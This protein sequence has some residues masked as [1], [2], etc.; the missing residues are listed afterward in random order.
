MAGVLRA[1]RGGGA[2]VL[3]APR[4]G[5]REEGRDEG[6]GSS[7][8]L[9]EGRGRRGGAGVPQSPARGRVAERG[10]Q[11]G[12]PLITFGNRLKDA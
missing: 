4:G 7:E 3:R 12:S 11:R 1:P 9:E 6:E 8:P 10:P 5:E 2:G